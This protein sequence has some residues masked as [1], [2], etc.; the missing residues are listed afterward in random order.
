[1]KIIDVDTLHDFVVVHGFGPPTAEGYELGAKLIAAGDDY[2]TAAMEI[3]SR[4][5]TTQ[6]E[7]DRRNPPR[8]QCVVRPSSH[9][10]A[11]TQGERGRDS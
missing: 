3:V 5:W 6:G 7:E 10:A 4:G 2:A 11:R 8:G 1:M 9:R